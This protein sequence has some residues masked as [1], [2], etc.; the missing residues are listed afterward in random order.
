LRGCG[1]DRELLK[2]TQRT[3]ARGERILQRVIMKAA[4]A[5]GGGRKH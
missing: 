2:V 1:S 3:I 5:E 4:D